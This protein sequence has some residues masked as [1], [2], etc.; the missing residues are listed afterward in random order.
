MNTTTRR[1]FLKTSATLTGA[2]L[3]SALSLE[4]SAHAAGS[5]VIRIGPIGCGGRGTEAATTSTSSE[6]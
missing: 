4:R 5:D 6:G 3:T 1:D 2:A